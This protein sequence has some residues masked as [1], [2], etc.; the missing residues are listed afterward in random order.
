MLTTDG[1]AQELLA[2][3]LQLGACRRRRDEVDRGQRQQRRG[4]T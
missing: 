1:V 3:V 2:R 4:H